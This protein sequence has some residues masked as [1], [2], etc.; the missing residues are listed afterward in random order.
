MPRAQK[1][2]KTKTQAT[3]EQS[4]NFHLQPPKTFFERDSSLYI[5]SFYLKDLA[6][7]FLSAGFEKNLMTFHYKESMVSGSDFHF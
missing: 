2:T 4:E 5:S 1:P 3:F 6:K 7:R